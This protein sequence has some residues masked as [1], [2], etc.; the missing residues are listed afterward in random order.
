[1]WSEFPHI[2]VL[3]LLLHHVVPAPSLLYVCVMG[4]CE[5]ASVSV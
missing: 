2:D 1:M 5:C 4:V 3:P